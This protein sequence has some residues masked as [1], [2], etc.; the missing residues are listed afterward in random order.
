M[1]PIRV[2]M[3]NN[4]F[5]FFASVA[6]IEDPTHYVLGEPFK[7]LP[8]AAAAAAAA[9]PKKNRLSKTYK[10]LTLMEDGILRQFT[11]ASR[12][13][14]TTDQLANMSDRHFDLFDKLAQQKRGGDKER[15]EFYRGVR[16]TGTKKKK[17]YRAELRRADDGTSTTSHHATPGEASIWFDFKAICR[18]MEE[19]EL[20]VDG[21]KVAGQAYSAFPNHHFRHYLRK[22]E[23]GKYIM[24]EYEQVREDMRISHP[25][26]FARP[27]T[28]DELL[29]MTDAA[30]K[31]KQKERKHQDRHRY[32]GVTKGKNYRRTKS[33]MIRWSAQLHLPSGKHRPSY[34][35][36]DTELQAAVAADYLRLTHF[37]TD[38]ITNFHYR[39]YL[40]AGPDGEEAHLKVPPPSTGDETEK[41]RKKREVAMIKTIAKTIAKTIKRENPGIKD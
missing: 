39:F 37:G 30:F 1:Y 15:G 23:Q 40:D 29:F 19:R 17:R 31:D 21:G 22:S 5:S 36:I 28:W 24:K 12:R 26:L 4:K 34:F 11:K 14:L 7:G 32:H 13:A 25:K 6:W 41:E 20:I 9:S 38:A 16:D 27:T 35:N 3:G 2:T 10:P 8:E 18:E 33:G